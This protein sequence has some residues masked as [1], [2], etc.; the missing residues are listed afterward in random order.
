MIEK[1]ARL[2]R[3]AES[4]TLAVVEYGSATSPIPQ[5]VSTAVVFRLKQRGRAFSIIQTPNLH[6]SKNPTVGVSKTLGGA[7]LVAAE[8]E[9]SSHM[10]P[11]QLHY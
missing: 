7:L 6:S 11:L 10:N 2:G 9:S 4:L 1:E 5:Y 8:R 3:K